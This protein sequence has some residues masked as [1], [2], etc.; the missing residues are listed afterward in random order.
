MMKTAT[1]LIVSALALGF[2]SQVMAQAA[3]E[4]EW[5]KPEKFRDV[6]PSNENRK[7]FKNATFRHIDEYM[8]KLAEDLPKSKKLLMTVSDLDLAGEVMP[9]SFAGLGHSASEVRVIKSIDIPRITFSYQL[10]G[11]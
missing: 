11:E 1:G 10:V 2:S 7:K 8:K 3:V 9:A 4:I 6:R 5:D